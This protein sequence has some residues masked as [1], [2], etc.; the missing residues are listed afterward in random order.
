MLSRLFAYASAFFATLAAVCLVPVA[1]GLAAPAAKPDLP[2]AAQLTTRAHFPDLLIPTGS[3]TPRENAALLSALVNYERRGRVDDF[4]S[5]VAFLEAYPYS[6]WRVALLTNLGSLYLHYGYFTRAIAAWDEAWREGRK[7]RGAYAKALVDEAV[8][9]LVLLDAELGHKNRV[10]RLLHEIAL[11]PVSGPATSFV[12]NA[13]EMLWVIGNDPKHLYL[14]GPEALATLMLAQGATAKGLSFVWKLR[15]DARGMSLAALARLAAKEKEPLLA[16]FRRPGEPVPVSSIVHW[17]VGH[18]AAIMGEKNGRYR[19]VDPVLG[20]QERWLTKAALDAE[21]SGY[22]L[23][24]KKEAKAA[25]WRL[26]AAAEGG[27]VWGAGPTAGPDPNDPGPPAD[28]PPDDMGMSQYNI[29]EL[30]V[31]V[32]LTDNPVG[33]VPPLGPSAEIT[34]AYNQYEADQPAVFGF[35]NISP[36]WT[37]NFLTHMVDDPNNPGSSVGRYRTYGG[38]WFYTGYNSATGAFVPDDHDDSVLVLV[39][40]SPITYGRYLKD[41]SVEVYAQS[42][43]ATS[44]PRNVF[45][46]KII[47]PR[48]TA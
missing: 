30:Q 38:A 24:P 21:G 11:R 22:F 10:A 28:P 27:K 6:S 4:S 47:D 17:K 35:F 31:G 45:L 37:F 39:S 2:M 8:G 23:A 15:A 16:V 9:K 32:I 7:V 36:K 29:S 13:R 1:Q 14:C 46:T 5:L 41:G 48:G 3:T 33:Y 20:R 44:Y 40:Q 34:L 42:D 18:Y 43:G 12:Q 19:V 26:V 25:G